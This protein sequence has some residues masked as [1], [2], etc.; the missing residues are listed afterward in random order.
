MTLYATR[1]GQNIT[2]HGNLGLDV[3][4]R[5]SQVQAFHVTDP[6]GLEHVR[7]FWRQLGEH[8][9]AADAEREQKAEE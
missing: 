4:V 8:L 7:Y 5:N 9:D 2:F 1:D 3:E 6:A